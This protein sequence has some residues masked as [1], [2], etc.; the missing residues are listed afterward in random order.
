VNGRRDLVDILPTGALGSNGSQF[1]L[2]ERDCNIVRNNDVVSHLAHYTGNAA[3][4]ALPISI[5]VLAGIF[6]MLAAQQCS[7]IRIHCMFRVALGSQERFDISKDS[8]GDR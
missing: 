6:F 3:W 2:G 4:A 5:M 8:A 1:N 7:R